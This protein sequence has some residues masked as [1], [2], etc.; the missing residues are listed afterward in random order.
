MLFVLLCL[1]LCYQQ[2]A[3]R[4]YHNVSGVG[5][6]GV[7]GPEPHLISHEVDVGGAP[8]AVGE[9]V[10][11]AG[12][13]QAALQQHTAGAEVILHLGRH[14]APA[15]ALLPVGSA[16]PSLLRLLPG[17]CSGACCSTGSHCRPRGPSRPK[18]GAGGAA[19]SSAPWRSP[20]WFGTPARACPCSSRPWTTPEGGAARKKGAESP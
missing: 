2:R 11:V 12:S 1:L 17:C 4:C 14:S 13:T 20:P 9:S 15:L 6:G 5:N 3:A 7:D 18:H 8:P 10:V 19:Q 16:S